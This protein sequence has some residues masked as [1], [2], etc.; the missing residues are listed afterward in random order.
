MARPENQFLFNDTLGYISP[1]A[2]SKRSKNYFIDTGFT[3]L[4]EAEG[5]S[6]FFDRDTSKKMAE[7]GFEILGEFARTHDIEK[8]IKKLKKA[9][10]KFLNK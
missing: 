4:N 10:I 8:T 5:V 1:N 3:L 9:R 2:N 7:V 6:Q